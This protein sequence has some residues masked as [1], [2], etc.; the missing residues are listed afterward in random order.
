MP[1]TA[2]AIEIFALWVSPTGT[3]RLLDWDMVTTPQHALS[4]GTA[5]DVSLAPEL[6]MW[7]DQ[8]AIWLRRPSNDPASEVLRAYRPH[9]GLRFGDVVFTGATDPG[10]DAVRG[11][12]E[13]QVLTLVDLYLLR[14]NA[15]M[16][17][18]Q[19]R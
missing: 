11:L 5:Q 18:A 8:D 19:C 9:P 6:A 1:A 12:T 3:F 2:T 10:A 17:G 4:C 7:T 13:D 14:V 15:P 16:P